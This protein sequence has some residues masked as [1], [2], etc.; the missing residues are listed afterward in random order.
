MTDR[1][2]STSADAFGHALMD[3]VHGEGAGLSYP[4]RFETSLPSVLGDS[5]DFWK[6]GLAQRGSIEVHGIQGGV[7]AQSASKVW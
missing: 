7:A 2:W 1:R 4:S 6:Q 3:Y 5:N